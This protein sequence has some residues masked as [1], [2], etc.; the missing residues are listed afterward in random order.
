LKINIARRATISI[1]NKIPS[2]KIASRALT[3]ISIAH[4]ASI[5][6]DNKIR[7]GKLPVGH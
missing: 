5:S 2:V 6:I 1:D 7:K 4:R 3:K